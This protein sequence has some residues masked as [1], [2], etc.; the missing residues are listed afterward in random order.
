M[1]VAARS[2]PL[3][4]REARKIL[5]GLGVRALLVLACGITGLFGYEVAGAQFGA[6]AAGSHGSIEIHLRAGGESAFRGAARVSLLSTGELPVEEGTVDGSDTARFEL[7][8]P[9]TYIVGASAPGFVTAT[10]TVEIKTK[11]SSITV[12]LQMKPENPENSAAA[13]SAPAIPILA[14]NGRREVEKGLEGFPLWSKPGI[15][16]IVPDGRARRCLC[17]S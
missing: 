14:P 6:Q 3:G 12:Y 1:F 9:A 10:K 4:G 7:L 5:H 11:W 17:A 8:P 15:D 2:R 13:A 16:E